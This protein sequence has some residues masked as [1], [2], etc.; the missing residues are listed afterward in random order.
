MLPKKEQLAI[1]SFRNWRIWE[2]EFKVFD[3]ILD[4]FSAHLKSTSPTKKTQT[5]E[6]MRNTKFYSALSGQRLSI[7]RDNQ[8]FV[9]KR[10]K[11]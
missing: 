10:V 6:E 9:L 3:K 2:A 8:S 1:R 11:N 4:P 7:A 5:L